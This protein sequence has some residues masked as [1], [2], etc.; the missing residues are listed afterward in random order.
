MTARQLFVSVDKS[1]GGRSITRAIASERKIAIGL[2]NELTSTL[3][4]LPET[5]GDI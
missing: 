2:M 4:T 5:I 1:P 3:D